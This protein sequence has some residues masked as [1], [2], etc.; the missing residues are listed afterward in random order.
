MTLRES[1]RERKRERGRGENRSGRAVANLAMDLR[2]GEKEERGS[3]SVTGQ[4]NEKTAK[5]PVTQKYG[6]GWTL[7][8]VSCPSDSS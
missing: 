3:H 1:E 4:T 6:L 2:V 7:Y 5:S 8:C